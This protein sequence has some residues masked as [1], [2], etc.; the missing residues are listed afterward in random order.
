MQLWLLLDAIRTSQLA[1]SR[2]RL[3][4]KYSQS[5]HFF[6]PRTFA[7]LSHARIFLTHLVLVFVHIIT[8]A[9]PPAS[10]ICALK[11]NVIQLQKGSGCGRIVESR[12]GSA[13]HQVHRAAAAYLCWHTGESRRALMGLFARGK[14]MLKAASSHRIQLMHTRI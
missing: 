3:P 5:R 9:F 10:S 12:H 8:A 1:V 13:S 6:N 4:S 2:S 14:L 11:T 7:A